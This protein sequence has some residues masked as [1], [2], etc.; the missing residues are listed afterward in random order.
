MH[1]SA[2]APQ[3][4]WSPSIPYCQPIQSALSRSSRTSKLREDT[5]TKYK[6]KISI[7]YGHENKKLHYNFLADNTESRIKKNENS[8]TAERWLFSQIKASRPFVGQY[9]CHCI[10]SPIV[11]IRK[12]VMYVP[13]VQLDVH[14][15]AVSVFYCLSSVQC[16]ATAAN[17]WS[18]G[19]F[20]KSRLLFSVETCL[21]HSKSQHE[22]K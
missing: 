22:E 21:R 7:P 2:G 1:F 19:L 4:T 11:W 10:L 5:H 14:N 6:Y 8:L 20:L 16:Q 18:Q 12:S 3:P 15:I 9:I 13:Y 17:D